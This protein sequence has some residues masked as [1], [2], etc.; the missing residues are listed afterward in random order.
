MS[1]AFA[2]RYGPWALIAGASEGLGAAFA[3]A[4]AARGLNLVL[5]ARRPEPLAALAQRLTTAHGVEVRTVSLD[6]GAADVGPQV[7]RLTAGLDVGLLVC[8]AAV[9]KVA[10]FF[11]VPWEEHQ[12]ALEVNCRAPLALCHAVG[13]RLKARG[14]GGIVIMSSLAGLI[15]GPYT[16]TYAASKA[17]DAT[18]AESLSGE[19]EPFGVHV[20]ACLAGPTATPTYEKNASQQQGLSPMSPRVVVEQTLN[21]LGRTPRFT[22]GLR[23][24]LVLWLT[25]LLPRRFLVRLVS[26]QMRKI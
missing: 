19:L 4:C 6:L 14:R 16:T 23:N 12:R 2:A 22:P 15:S 8:N 17:F 13:P 1:G 9:S 7:E 21:A 10:G 24:R 3:E 5:L 26:A 20:L 11:E 18:L 25:G